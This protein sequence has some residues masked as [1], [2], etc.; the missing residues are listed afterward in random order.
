MLL[1]KIGEFNK[2]GV[3]KKSCK[4]IKIMLLINILVLGFIYFTNH[5]NYRMI[6]RKNAAQRQLALFEDKIKAASERSKAKQ[7]MLRER[8]L[9][10]H[11]Q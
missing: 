5:Q 7:P 1:Q 8:Y 2:R 11:Q 9:K 6:E 3:M 4:F 10:E